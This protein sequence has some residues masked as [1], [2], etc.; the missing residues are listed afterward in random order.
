M[1][2]KFY[3]M[4]CETT[5]TV[6][7]GPITLSG[8]AVPS[9]I[10][11]DQ[12]GVGDNETIS[13]CLEEMNHREIGHGVYTTSLRRLT[14]IVARSTNNNAP[15]NLAGNARCSIVLTAEDLDALGGIAPGLATETW[16]QNWVN[17]RGFLTA[18]PQPLINQQLTDPY[19]SGNATRIMGVTTP[20]T[21]PVVAGAVG[22]WRETYHGVSVSAYNAPLVTLS[23]PPGDWDVGGQFYISSEPG[24]A[25]SPNLTGAKLTYTNA[26]P[27]GLWSGWWEE[28]VKQRSVTMP[29]VNAAFNVTTTVGMDVDFGAASGT[30]L[31]VGWLG[32][33]RM[34]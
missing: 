8:I 33:R 19:I 31:I 28:M 7:N 21:N 10:T 11:F 29:T 16:V 30:Y 5:T 15:I 12:A 17:G 14:R 6:G 1:P 18:V 26:G 22:E 3:N 27:A 2:S 24:G 13:Y 23:L 34:R 9:F 25:G 20:L 4:A 32:A